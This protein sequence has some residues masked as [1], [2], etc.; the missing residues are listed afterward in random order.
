[1][2]AGEIIKKLKKVKPETAVVLLI[3]IRG[4]GRRKKSPW[5]RDFRINYGD[6]NGTPLH[7]FGY[8]EDKL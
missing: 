2:T 8:L 3:H 1:M 6:Y 4:D 5:V 7:L